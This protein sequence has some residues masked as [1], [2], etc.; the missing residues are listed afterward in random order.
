M[1]NAKLEAVSNGAAPEQAGGEDRSLDKVHGLVRRAILNGDLQPG[2]IVSQVQLAQDLGVSRTPLREALRLL[3]RE[4]L[5][6]GEPNRRVR[7]S[8]LSVE[9]LEE[10]YTLRIVNE[11]VGIQLT[12]PTMT[13]ADIEGL[14]ELIAEMDRVAELRDRERWEVPHREFHRRL[15]CGFGTR[16]AAFLEELADHSERYRR[17][18]L[19]SGPRAWT[20]GPAEHAKILDACEQGDAQEASALLV[21]HISRTALFVLTQIAPE[22]EPRNLRAALRTVM[23]GDERDT[24]PPAR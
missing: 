20:I 22:H 4:G 13:A 9:D 16:P 7:V 14:R 17:A 3:Q 15:V 6:E 21:R 24:G 5:V 18:H 2:L 12:V 23:R 19:E 10:L 11:S 8:P 1:P